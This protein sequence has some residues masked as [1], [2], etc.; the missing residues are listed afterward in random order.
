VKLFQT[1]L[2]PFPVRVRLALYVKGLDVEL[3]EPPGFGDGDTSKGDYLSLNPMGRVPTLV[4][5][6]GRALPESEV[7]CEYLN[8]AFPMPSLLPKDPWAR[9]QVRLLSR[10]CDVYVVM[11]MQPLFGLVARP[12]RERSPAA[13]DSALGNVSEALGFVERYIGGDG[14]AVGGS[15]THADGVVP[16]MLLLACEWAQPLFGGPDPLSRFPRLRSYRES[17]E[18][19]PAVA[20]ALGEMRQPLHARVRQRRESSS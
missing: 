19:D 15:L 8:E 18:K 10:I 12:K 5:D 20:R 13:I 1:F 2:S 3:V 17:I 11:A 4:L 9:A 16:P 6:D 7:I 14:Y